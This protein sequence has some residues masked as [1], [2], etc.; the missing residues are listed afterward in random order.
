MSTK[1]TL[2]PRFILFFILGFIITGYLIVGLLHLTT[3]LDKTHCSYHS[4]LMTMEGSCSQL[5]FIL[6]N[7]GEILKLIGADYDYQTFGVL[8]E[9]EEHIINNAQ[10]LNLTQNETIEIINVFHDFYYGQL[11]DA[12]NIIFD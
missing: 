10:L 5:M 2:W 8:F 6:N 7:D 11:R 1:K 9:W 4:P 12:H 3:T